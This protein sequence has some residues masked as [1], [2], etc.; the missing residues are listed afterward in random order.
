MELTTNELFE[1]FQ[2]KSTL[3]NIKISSI[4]TDSRKIQENDVFIAIKGEQF[5]GHD[6]VKEV[7]QKGALLAV[8]EHKIEDVPLER[9]II[10][11]SSL[12]A[13]GK[14]GAYM[15][16]KFK[17]T[18]I[19][20]TGSA[21]KTTTKE[22]LKFLLSHF[23]KT[24]AT[25]GNHNNF[26]GVPQSLCEIDLTA[27]YAIIEMGMSA[28]GEIEKLVSYV[29]PDIALVTN[30]FPMHIE[31]LK[32]I[33]NIA[34]AKAEIF[35]ALS[36]NGIAV[37]NADTNCSDIL[38]SIASEHT[39]HIFLFGKNHLPNVPFQTQDPGENHF[40]N[41]LACLKTIE[42]LGLDVQKAATFIKDFGPLEGRGKKHL[43]HLSKDATYTLINDSYS[44]Q[45]EAMKL[46]VK[47]LDL[48]PHHGRKIAVLGKMAE[49]GD[50]SKEAH[51][52]IG[53]VVS[54][55]NIDIVIGV[56]EEMKDMLSLL[57]QTIK[58]YYFESKDGLA[59][60]LLNELLQND[61]ILLIKGARYSSKLYMVA[62]ELIKKGTL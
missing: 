55:T 51:R 4:S 53:E 12:E 13:Y 21:G 58:Q 33:E 5:D 8:V 15:R 17:G 57:P 20:L 16:S 11:S 36:S 25:T 39:N 18:V 62:D 41:A 32:T 42:A 14:I 38:E 37:I 2:I 61:D 6:Y 56:C 31:F 30:V 1:L 35:S 59:Q 60:F 29:K 26:I 34:R 19:G 40:Y 27:D 50:F 9:Q 3:N 28:Q 47:A 49:L 48:M 43:L 52:Q 7:I 46:A 45:P 24:Y 10:V 54:K 23:G 44:G 22:E